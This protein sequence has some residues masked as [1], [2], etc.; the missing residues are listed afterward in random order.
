MVLMN[1]YY[2]FSDNDNGSITIEKLSKHDYHWQQ[3]TSNF[4]RIF[5]RGGVRFFVCFDIEW[6]T[7]AQATALWTRYFSGLGVQHVNLGE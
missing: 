1:Y 5:T 7:E 2:Y 3:K 4:A 6:I